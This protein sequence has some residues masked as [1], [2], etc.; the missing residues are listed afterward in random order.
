MHDFV[1]V[2][3]EVEQMKFYTILTDNSKNRT[4]ITENGQKIKI[5]STYRLLRLFETK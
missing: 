3:F 4:L 5:S 2:K 1:H